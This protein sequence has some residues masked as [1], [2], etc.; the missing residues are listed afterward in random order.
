MN[1]VYF[2]VFSYASAKLASLPLSNISHIISCSLFISVQAI[3]KWGQSQILTSFESFANVSGH[4][5]KSW[6][7]M[8][9]QSL[10]RVR[11]FVISWTVGLPGSSVRG[12]LQARI[13]ERVAI[14]SSRVSSQPRDRTSISSF[15]RCILLPLSHL[16]S[17]CP[18]QSL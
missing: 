6:S 5:S 4:W 16:G 8:T 11:L 2:V 13:L 15:D 9:A 14:S 18:V 1:I 7:S 17:P 3:L 12:I 10:S